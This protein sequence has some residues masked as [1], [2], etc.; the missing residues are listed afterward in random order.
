MKIESLKNTKNIKKNFFNWKDPFL[1]EDQLETDE[2]II[3]NTAKNF[4]IEKL[5]PRIKSP[6]SFNEKNLNFM[7]E[8]GELGLLGAQLKGYGCAGASQVAYG[9][10]AREVESIDSGLR[11]ALSVQSSLV[12][13]PIYDFGNEEQ[14]Q[15]WI[16][17]LAKGKLIGCFG[18]TEPNHGSDPSS[19][20]TKAKKT[21]GGVL[22][23]GSKNWITNSP[24]AD[25]LIVWAKN[26]NSEIKGYVIER[27]SSKGLSTPEIKDKLAFNFSTTG[28]IFMDEVFVPTE[29]ILPN[30]SGLKSVLNC[31]SSAR[32][33]IA[34]G[35]LGAAEYC[36]HAARNYVLER[37]QFGKPL[38]SNQLIQKK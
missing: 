27:K 37:K 5:L 2:K 23:S 7:Q 9:L 19:M 21:K 30:T 3:R 29:N 22:L 13:Q 25:L 33:G 28:M 16:P 20:Q 36:W 1:L 10:I 15:R 11:S 17:E 18:L 26:E 24:I 38:A 14:K 6:E 4:S 34:W 35:T 31:L 8:I 32:Y 12:M